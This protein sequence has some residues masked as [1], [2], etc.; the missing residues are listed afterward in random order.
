MGW[1]SDKI[2][3]AIGERGRRGRERKHKE[4]KEKND[5]YVLY[6]VLILF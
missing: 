6:G 1:A 5:G 3:T 4:V 2:T